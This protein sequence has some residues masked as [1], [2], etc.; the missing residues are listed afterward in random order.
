MYLKYLIQNKYKYQIYP[1]MIDGIE[2][3]KIQ[4]FYKHNLHETNL[5]ETMKYQIK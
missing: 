1:C 4:I 2:T 5:S 3:V